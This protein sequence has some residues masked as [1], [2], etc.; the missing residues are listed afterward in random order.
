MKTTSFIGAGR[1]TGILLQGLQNKNMLFESIDVF[2]IDEKAIG[3][4]QNSFPSVRK[5]ETISDAVTNKTLL[6]LAVHP[7][8]FKEIAAEIRQL[9]D[10]RTIILSLIPKITID[11]LC[12]AF[13]ENKNIARMNPNA[14]SIVNEG[15]NPVSFSNKFDSEKKKEFTAVFSVL[16]D[17]P[18]TEDALIEAF[19]VITA[20]G[21]TYFDYQFTALINKAIEFGIDEKSAKLAVMKLAIGTA[22]TISSD[23]V[24]GEEKLNLVPVRPLAEIESSLKNAFNEK[25]SERFSMLKS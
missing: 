8:V 21:Y 14:P 4:I 9:I 19:A 18:Q 24:R 1:I 25:L 20:M 6:I 5:S 15:Y 16:G 22:K 3:K 23:F 17:M 10:S 2:D 11:K 13:P 7:P 12:A